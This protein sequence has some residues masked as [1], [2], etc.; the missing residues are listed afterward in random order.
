MADATNVKHVGTQ[1]GYN[2]WSE[3]YDATP[4]PVVS[5]DS[6]HTIKYLAPAR[7][8]LILD[9]GCGTGRN[10]KQL[11][12]TG[13]EPIGIDFSFGMLKVA[14]HEIPDAKVAMANLEQ[15][16]PFRESSFDAVLC[17]LIGEHLSELAGVLQEF[18]RILKRRGRLVFSVY[19]PAMSAAGIEANFE[20]SGIEY[21]LGAIHYSVS[22][23]IRLFEDAGFNEIG[24]QEFHGDDQL[25]R[26][27]PSASKYLDFPVLLI[28]GAI[29]L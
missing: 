18:W 5:M 25:I 8:E 9:A 1:Q 14:R 19:H 7:G 6:R 17:A 11:I 15:P 12:V 2:L 24:V 21:R 13:S 27:V 16:L 20:H 10:L 28:L 22:E 23:H 4:N 29:K 26:S 3:I